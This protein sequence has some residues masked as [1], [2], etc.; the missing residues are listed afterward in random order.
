LF[1]IIKIIFLRFETLTLEFLVFRIKK[2]DFGKA[3]HFKA[4]NDFFFFKS[5]TN[6]TKIK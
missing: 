3:F 1:T 4:K 6:T 5:K 2:I